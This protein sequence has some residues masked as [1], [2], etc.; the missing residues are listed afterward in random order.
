MRAPRCEV[1]ATNQIDSETAVRATERCS[2]CADA[3]TMY[4][5]EL[6]AD[7]PDP[8]YSAHF[9][10]ALMSQSDVVTGSVSDE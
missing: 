5:N 10:L 3:S 6:R 7:V 2:W 4:T 1:R 9:V 8:W